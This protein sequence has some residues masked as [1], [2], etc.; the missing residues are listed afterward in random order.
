MGMEEIKYDAFIGKHGETEEEILARLTKTKDFIFVPGQ[1]SATVKLV[2]FFF[3]DSSGR[4]CSVEDV[5]R[6]EVFMHGIIRSCGGSKR[7]DLVIGNVDVLE[8]YEY[9]HHC[10]QVWKL[11]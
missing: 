1:S 9:E 6:K 5:V 2:D 7:K 10:S 8:W 4:L 3:V 11:L